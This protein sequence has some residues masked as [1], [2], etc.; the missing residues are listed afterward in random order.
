MLRR[1]VRLNLRQC[2][3]TRVVYTVSLYTRKRV[4][5]RAYHL[6]TNS[7]QTDIEDLVIV[8][9]TVYFMRHAGGHLPTIVERK[10]N[11][12]TGPAA[13]G[14]SRKGARISSILLI[15]C[16]QELLFFLP[17]SRR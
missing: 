11:V 14:V 15:D 5:K 4:C 6:H 3:H 17:Q 9:S 8:G 2:L 12:L 7:K 16:G 1:S 10:D 13:L